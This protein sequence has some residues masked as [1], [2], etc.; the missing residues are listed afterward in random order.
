MTVSCEL[1]AVG[2]LPIQRV[3]EY[4]PFG[5]ILSLDV[6]CKFR[7]LIYAMYSVGRYVDCIAAVP[8]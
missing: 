4:G 8:R 2:D 5:A 7:T 1:L 3:A 6:V